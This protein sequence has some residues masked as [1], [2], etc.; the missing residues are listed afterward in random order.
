MS[1]KEKNWVNIILNK[2]ITTEMFALICELINENNFYCSLTALNCQINSTHFH[3]LST[4]LV[5][6]PLP[7]IPLPSLYYTD[8]YYKE[9]ETY[10]NVARQLRVECKFLRR[11]EYL[12]EE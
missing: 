4:L 3:I 2:E 10:R 5:P 12:D 9:G 6:L 8:Y 1:M 7:L 11:V